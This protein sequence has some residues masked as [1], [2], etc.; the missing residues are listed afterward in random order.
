M[1]DLDKRSPR[2]RWALFVVATVALAAALVTCKGVSDNVLVPRPAVTPAS[3]CI[4]DCAHAAN[5]AMRVESDLHVSNVKA[6]AGDSLCLANEAARHVAA[7][8]AIQAQRQQ[9][10]DNCHQQG[11]GNGGH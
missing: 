1:R 11:G 10:Q 4:A 8:N 2:V 9:C 5:D 7:V 6:C 3:D